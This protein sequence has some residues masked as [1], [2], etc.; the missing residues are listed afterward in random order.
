MQQNE[1]NLMCCS[2]NGKRLGGWNV[3]RK[4]AETTHEA[5]LNSNIELPSSLLFLASEGR[6]VH[7]SLPNKLLSIF[8]E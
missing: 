7:R 4:L 6:P 5:P 8:L 3:F 1:V 2:G